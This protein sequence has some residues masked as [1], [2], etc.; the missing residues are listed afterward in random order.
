[1]HRSFRNLAGALALGAACLIAAFQ[2]AAAQGIA[3]DMD[4]RGITS[5]RVTASPMTVDSLDCSVESAAMVRE[6][7][8]QLV[9]EGMKATD[10]DAALAV[11]T[12]LS[13]RDA[14][15][16][17]CNS[18]LMLGAY[19]KASFFDKDV[20]WIRTGYVVMWQSAVLVSSPSETHSVQVRDGLAKLG[21]ALLGDWRN[22]N[23]PV[24][25]ASSQ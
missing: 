1:M 10:S 21:D 20:G 4:L 25:S 3:T 17:V 11:V 12:V 7:R 8:Q 14:N 22:A 2:P 23:R 18:T 24:N 6:L 13:T 16:D 15:T 9:S 5:L 19:K